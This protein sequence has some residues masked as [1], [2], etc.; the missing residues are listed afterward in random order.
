MLI[1]ITEHIYW[2]MTNRFATNFKFN[3]QGELNHLQVNKDGQ[4]F[5]GQ[6]PLT[7]QV[8]SGSGNATIPYDGSNVLILD[9]TLSA[10]PLTVDFSAMNN[11]YGRYVKFIAYQTLAN[12]CTLDFGTGNIYFPP[13]TGSSHTVVLDPASS[14]T[15]R[16]FHFVNPTTAVVTYNPTVAPSRILPGGPGQVLTTNAGTGLVDW[17]NPISGA[18]RILN[19]NWSTDLANDLNTNTAE[20][21]SWIEDAPNNTTTLTLGGGTTPGTCQTFTV[22][23]PGP[24]TITHQ[25]FVVGNPSIG[26]RNFISIVNQSSV[27]AYNESSL[28]LTGQRTGGSITLNLAED[29]VIAVYMGNA[30]GTVTPVTPLDSTFGTLSIIQH[31]Y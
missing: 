30:T 27:W 3:T 2:P 22:T 20:Q 8:Y 19:F 12:N 6:V 14:P 1:L 25:E 16:E 17:E 9:T 21:I 29:D 11:W 23:T 18:P 7:Y 15:V 10:G 28:G 13:F 4:P 26:Y 24:Y 31:V 5:Q